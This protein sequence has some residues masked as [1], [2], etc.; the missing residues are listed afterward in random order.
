MKNKILIAGKPI[1]D[2]TVIISANA[3]SSVKYAAGELIKYIEKATGVMLPLADD[4]SA[5]G[6]SEILVGE[7]S[8][9]KKPDDITDE[10]TEIFCSGGTLSLCGG[11]DRATIYSVYEYLE[12][13]VGWRFFA[14]D[15]EVLTDT[16]NSVII[17]GERLLDKP[18]FK[19]RDNFFLDVLKIPEFRVKSRQN[20]SAPIPENMG[21]ALLYNGFV[22]TF[23][24]LIPPSEYFE[25]HPEYFGLYHGKRETYQPCLS[26]PEVLKIVTENVLNRLRKNKQFFVS[27][28]QND[29]PFYCE[30]ENCLKIDEEEGSH[31]GTLIRFVNAVAD[32]VKKEFPDVRV[33]TLAYQ[34]TRKLP[35]HTLP[36]DNMTIRLCSIEC[37]FRHPMYDDDCEQNKLFCDDIRQWSSTGNELFVWDYVTD[38]S[39][40]QMPFPNLSIIRQNMKFFADHNVKGLLPQGTYNYHGSDFDALKTY[41]FNKLLWNPYISKYEFEY[42][43]NDF[44]KG[45]YGKGWEYLRKYLEILDET[46]SKIH[47]GCFSSP[48]DIFSEF[49]KRIDEIYSLFDK[50]YELAETS[51]QKQR[52]RTD[53]IGPLYVDL[54][55]NHEKRKEEDPEKLLADKKF[56]YNEMKECGINPC[57][58]NSYVSEDQ[59]NWD[60]PPYNWR[61]NDK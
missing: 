59:I 42:H 36:R 2:F 27:V 35:L 41:L 16:V 50:A 52:V 7:T 37:C 60:D 57:E 43:L 56:Y 17:N 1:S 15:C 51:E 14:A 34:H 32:E 23:N 44:L 10:M 11:C 25:E 47:I 20:T 40:Y 38:F 31:A 19:Y 55:L 26:N 8:R 21:G 3:S 18:V 45:Y 5:P 39:N 30:C 12:K 54:C 53:R 9:R 48:Y 6:A 13:I 33:D 28:S 22:H 4:S 58:W 24:Q 49:A 46:T 61:R 29:N